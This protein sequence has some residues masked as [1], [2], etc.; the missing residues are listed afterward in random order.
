MSGV[1]NFQVVDEKEDEEEK[2]K[3]RRIGWALDRQSTNPSHAH[4]WQRRDH[5]ARMFLTHV[6]PSL[7]NGERKIV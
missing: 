6:A 7:A 3:I 4:L 2:N 5:S 1:P